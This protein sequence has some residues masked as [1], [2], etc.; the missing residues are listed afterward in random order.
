LEG[1]V[2]PEVAF[3][4]SPP[5]LSSRVQQVYLQVRRGASAAALDI[6]SQEGGPIEIQGRHLLYV[7]AVLGM[8]QLHFVDRHRDV[9]EREPFAL[10]AQPPEG[11]GMLTWDQ[12]QPLDLDVRDLRKAGEPE[13]YFD[14]LPESINESTDFTALKNDLDDYLYHNSSVTLLHSPALD[15]YSRPD[16]SE[17]E[18]RMRLQQVARERRDEEIDKITERYE[19]K[20]ER[21]ED[22]L[23][24]SEAD[25]SE[26]EVDVAARKRE[27]LVSVGES[28]VGMFLGRRSTRMASTALSKQRQATKAKLRLEEAAEE[29]E[30]LKKD[31]EELE[32]ELQEHVAAIR[33]R[34]EEALTDLDEHDVRP[35]RQDVQ[36]NL[37]GLAWTPHWQIAF[38]DRGGTSRT[39]LVA[40]F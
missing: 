19:D 24:R 13:A 27:T 40:A 5:S 25:L 30:E 6:E 10:L 37:F 16:E 28:V 35:R 18:L 2:A 22:R 17:R 34:W 32:E 33:D 11:A 15:T 12:A 26:R 39:E 8:G 36:I 9:S 4:A 7:P 3:A 14:E 23:R 38:Q 31:V 1:A 21:L 20:L 29:V